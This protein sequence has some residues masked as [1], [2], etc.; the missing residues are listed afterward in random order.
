MIAGGA[1]GGMEIRSRSIHTGNHHTSSAK[2]VSPNVRIKM[3]VTTLLLCVGVVIL[4]TQGVGAVVSKTTEYHTLK[5][6]ITA[7]KTQNIIL[8]DGVFATG[9]VKDQSGRPVPGAFVSAT[10]LQSQVAA[11]GA[12]TDATGKFT[13]P[14]QPGTYTFY[15]TPPGSTSVVPS[16]FSRLLRGKLEN[17]SIT[18]ATS[19]GTITLQ[20]GFILSGKI[21]AP[22]G[23]LGIFGGVLWTF[24]TVGGPIGF[25]AAQFGTPPTG[26]TQYAIALA[27]GSYKRVLIPFLA[28]SS[29]F[30][31]L[32][33]TFSTSSF[34]LNSD[35][36]MNLSLRKGSMLSGT[37]HDAAGKNVKGFVWIY[38]KGATVE[39]GVYVAIGVVSNGAYQT[40]LPAG[41][42]TATFVPSQDPSYTGR[43]AM[44]SQDVVMTAANK[45]LNFTAKN[46]VVLSGTVTDARNKVM[47]SSGVMLR[48][49]ANNPWGPSQITYAAFAATTSSGHYRVVVPAGTYDL[50]AFPQTSG[51]APQH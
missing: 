37:V 3:K 33:L 29:T 44:T 27:P 20:N 40:F 12:R 26:T 42:F 36:T 25:Q 34:T 16:A 51:S 14:V 39:P 5:A 50:I 38:Q 7:D 10:Q 2:T 19:V 35:K 30:Q 48:G 47:K 13:I 43:A 32:P 9:F 22:T 15:V 49:S 21:N 46:G 18:A 6:S 17:I 31:T 11:I 24:P 23:P 4:G 1:V 41:N 45:V 28:Y 8:P